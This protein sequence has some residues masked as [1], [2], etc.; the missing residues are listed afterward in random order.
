M[1]CCH[2]KHLCKIFVGFTVPA[3]TIWDYKVQ[4][5]KPQ[6]LQVHFSDDNPYNVE[7]NMKSTFFGALYVKC[8]FSSLVLA[9]TPMQC[10]EKCHSWKCNRI[11]DMPRSPLFIKCAAACVHTHAIYIPLNKEVKKNSPVKLWPLQL[12]RQNFHYVH[13]YW[14]WWYTLPKSNSWYT[15]WSQ[16]ILL[17]FHF[18]SG[19]RSGPTRSVRNGHMNSKSYAVHTYKCDTFSKGWHLIIHSAAVEYSAV[20]KIIANA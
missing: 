16:A 11:I 3:H 17:H 20:N 5:L 2:S 14:R 8:A 15:S 6:L 18:M 4:L 19:M 13:V 9:K 1:S 12:F 7:S 10:F